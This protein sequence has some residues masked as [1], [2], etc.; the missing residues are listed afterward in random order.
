ML[1]INWYRAY[2]DDGEHAAARPPRIDRSLGVRVNTTTGQL[3][4]S[5]GTRLRLNGT[6][7]QESGT[8]MSDAQIAA[9]V[10]RIR[11]NGYNA[12]RLHAYYTD[13]KWTGY[14][15]ST[16]GPHLYDSTDTTEWATVSNRWLL[17]EDA[18]IQLDRTIA[19]LF[20]AGIEFIMMSGNSY[21]PHIERHS[22]QHARGTYLGYGMM[23]SDE[24]RGI[25]KESLVRFYAR[26]NTVTG[27][28][29]CD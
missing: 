29:Y 7:M 11:G 27:V 16:W 18:L 9:H 17:N 13:K 6:T 2:G 24:Y 15:G 3:V 28:A 4:R 21:A 26:V 1:G 10:K 19:S 20:D 25:I 12:V 22:S 8:M 5:D 23:W 14:S